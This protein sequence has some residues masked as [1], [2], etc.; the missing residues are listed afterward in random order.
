MNVTFVSKV[1]EPCKMTE[2]KEQQKHSIV[3]NNFCL[4]ETFIVFLR[5]PGDIQEKNHN[6]V[7]MKYY[8]R[9]YV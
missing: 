4:W 2:Q 6:L 1:K 7:L 3:S 8:V 9:C 5:G